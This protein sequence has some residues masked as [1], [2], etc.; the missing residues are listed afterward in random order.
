MRVSGFVSYLGVIPHTGRNDICP[1]WG[2][3]ITQ[4]WSPVTAFGVIFLEV[5]MS[6]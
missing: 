3:M 5:V 4:V 2:R 1:A 6:I